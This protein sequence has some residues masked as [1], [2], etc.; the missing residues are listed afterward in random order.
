MKN[1]PPIRFTILS[2]AFVIV[3]VLPAFEFACPI[4]GGTGLLKAAQ[5]LKVESVETRLISEKDVFTFGECGSP[6]RMSRF[7]NAV[8]MLLT[9]T[10]TEPSRGTISVIFSRH[11]IGEQIMVQ[12]A[13]GEM[14][15]EE[16]RP[17]TFPAYVAVPAGTTKNIERVLSF[18]DNPLLPED[19]PY[20]V[21][22]EAGTDMR[23][24]TCG[25]TGKL[26]FIEWLKAIVIGPPS[27][28]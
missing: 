16:F 23:D 11:P 17:P 28:E 25:G 15:Y 20:H 18:I 12:N 19:K 24:P 22:V 3:G 9:N 14:V 6:M 8:D 1:L 5:G 27:F 21:T 7:T 2:V 4:D 13:E 10:S 26:H